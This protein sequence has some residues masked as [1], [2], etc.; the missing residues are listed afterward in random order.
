MFGQLMFRDLQFAQRE[1]SHKVKKRS[2]HHHKTSDSSFLQD[3]PK[4]DLYHIVQLQDKLVKDGTLKSHSDLERFWDRIQ[5]PDIFFMYFNTPKSDDMS[6]NNDINLNE[7][8]PINAPPKI[9]VLPNNVRS[10]SPRGDKDQGK[11]KT[12]TRITETR[13]SSRPNTRSDQW[14]ITQQFPAQNR[15]KED[16]RKS[17]FTG[18]TR[19]QVSQT[20]NKLNFQLELE[21]RFPKLEMPK[22]HCFTMSLGPKPPDPEEVRH[23]IRLHQLEKNRKSY[24]H[25]LTKM[26]QLAMANAA[27][28]SRI[29]E[30]HEDIDFIIN[31]SPLQDLISD[32]HFYSG[33]PEKKAEQRGDTEPPTF[34]TE[35]RKHEHTSTKRSKVSS[36]TKNSVQV[37]ASSKQYSRK[38]KRHGQSEDDDLEDTNAPLEALKPQPLNMAEMKAKART[39][40]AKC[41]SSFWTNYTNQ[42]TGVYFN[43]PYKV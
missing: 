2:E 25:R 32:Q 26:H 10:T 9:K 7:N 5:Q 33:L 13:E 31:G 6:R 19:P 21:K 29:L 4:T 36:S 24:T 3:I 39:M 37:S 15:V 28:S 1:G 34:I 35:G 40:S 14:A 12:L 42:G 41:L 43:E 23:E 8:A 17:S 38:I 27:A 20:Q 30:T 22:L 18:L 11:A 16:R